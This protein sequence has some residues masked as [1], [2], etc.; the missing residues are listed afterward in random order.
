MFSQHAP[1]GFLNVPYVPY[2]LLA[3]TKLTVVGRQ[4]FGMNLHDIG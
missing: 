4:L 1:I 2:S 3:D